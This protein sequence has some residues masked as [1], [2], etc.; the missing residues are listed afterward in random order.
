MHTFNI[1]NTLIIK[2]FQKDVYHKDENRKAY[3]EIIYIISGSG[4]HFVNEYIVSYRSGDIFVI[5]PEDK[6]HFE[7]RETT[8]FSYFQFTHALFLS[9]TNLPS[10]A[11]W[12]LRIEHIVRNTSLTPGDVIRSKSDRNL[13]WHMH[14]VITYEY[15]NKKPFYIQNI[16][17]MISTILSIISRNVSIDSQAGNTGK[18][19]RKKNLIGNVT[20]Y[21]HQNIYDKKLMKAK[22]IAEQ[23]DMSTSGLSA[24]FKRNTGDSLHH[25][26]LQ[27][28]LQLVKKRLENSDFTIGDIA[29]QLGFTDE[30]HL[31]RIFKK[32]NDN[33]SPKQFKSDNQSTSPKEIKERN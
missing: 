13:I 32:Y 29:K 25:Y 8:T 10:R 26:I 31:T 23:F 1:E 15:Q 3:L 12:L 11:Y 19:L 30:S 7:I 4:K 24:F 28:R 9:K 27:Y 14:D 20:D 21:I 6:H 16:G 33:I 5:S 22:A 2:E 18:R 17:D